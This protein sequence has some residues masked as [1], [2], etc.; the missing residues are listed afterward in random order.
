MPDSLTLATYPFETVRVTCTKCGRDGAYSR[1]RLIARYG[2]P[3][4]MPDVLREPADC[5]C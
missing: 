4:A 1:T 2:R 3:A 5:A